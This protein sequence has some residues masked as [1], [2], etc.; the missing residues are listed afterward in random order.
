MGCGPA[1]AQFSSA[2]IDVVERH[3]REDLEELM[4]VVLLLQFERC[5]AKSFRNGEKRFVVAREAEVCQVTFLS[6]FLDL[7]TVLVLLYLGQLYFFS[8]MLFSL[9]SS[10]LFIFSPLLS[11]F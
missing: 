10:S 6:L 1:K 8:L 4:K 2:T 3:W 5:V 11:L 7:D 9:T